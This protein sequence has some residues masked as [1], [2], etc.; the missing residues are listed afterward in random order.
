[1]PSE[2]AEFA[3]LSRWASLLN[4]PDPVAVLEAELALTDTDGIREYAHRTWGDGNGRS[5]VG[6]DAQVSVEVLQRRFDI[7]AADGW[8][9]RSREGFA[10]WLSRMRA[11]VESTAGRFATIGGIAVA[12]AD[13][14]DEAYAECL[15]RFADAARQV[16]AL[17]LGRDED[18]P[19]TRQR[20]AREIE[21]AIKA[22]AVCC[23]RVDERVDELQPAVE[24]LI[25][26]TSA[27]GTHDPAGTADWEPL[28]DPNTRNVGN[29]G[30]RAHV[31]VPGD[32]LS[33]L[34]ARYLGDADRWPEI[35]AANRGLIA[36]AD[37]IYPGQELT[38]PT[39]GGGEDTAGVPE[40]GEP[41]LPEPG[42]PPEHNGEPGH[43][44][45]GAPAPD[46]VPY[47]PAP[48]PSNEH[49]AP[50]PSGGGE[51][52]PGGNPDAE[53]SAGPAVPDLVSEVARVPP[54]V[55]VAA[56]LAAA[57]L[58]AWA[59]GVLLRRRSHSPTDPNSPPEPP[60]SLVE[61]LLRHASEHPGTTAA[62][63]HEGAPV[64][65]LGVDARGAP[66][67]AR[68]AAGGLGLHGPGADHAARAVIAGTLCAGGPLNP[69]EK[70]IVV[71]THDVLSMLTADPD[72]GHG[73]SR[74]V[75][76]ADIG[77]VL[78]WLSIEMV[79]RRRILQEHGAST[80]E[81]LPRVDP[82]AAPLPLIVAVLTAPGREHARALQAVLD[83]A[84]D[85]GVVAVLL[86]EWPHASVF[87]DGDCQVSAP[88]G[89]IASSAAGGSLHGGQLAGLSASGFVDA[90]HVAR[91]AAAGEPGDVVLSTVP[92]P[93]P[94]TTSDRIAEASAR[95]GT[96]TDLDPQPASPRITPQDP[97]DGGGP[98]APVAGVEQPIDGLTEAVPD[99]LPVDIAAQLQ[100]DDNGKEAAAEPV[101]DSTATPGTRA[102]V[103]DAG[104]TMALLTV[105]DTP[106]VIAGDH[107]LLRGLR[108]VAREI[109][110]WLALH[111]GGGTAADIV[112]DLWPGRSADDK[113]TRSSFRGAVHN[114]RSALAA[115]CRRPESGF[116][117]H[118]R[119]TGRYT[120]SDPDVR[121]EW[122]V[123]ES[124][125]RE[126]DT[127]CALDD[128]D[129]EVRALHAA[130]AL[131]R[132]PLAE[133]WQSAWLVTF[134]QD[135]L[136]QA[137]RALERLSD[138]ACPDHLDEA[139]SY[140]QQAIELDPYAEPCY[141]ALMQ[142]QAARG[143]L[144]DVRH[145]LQR[146]HTQLADLDAEP[147]Q[148]TIVLAGKLLAGHT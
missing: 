2:L 100:G 21:R 12:A 26:P 135:A 72:P 121:S 22:V 31:V 105:F 140:L 131:C 93:R 63:P 44:E 132:A 36:D 144:D 147:D 98:G 80:V 142:V 46:P 138:L 141:R 129:G 83:Q 116:V 57:V 8:Q 40:T 137:T 136:N 123:F 97:V 11:E 47:R 133:G 66:I 124:L 103:P 13:T 81:E 111:P 113:N 143:D 20:V 49:E 87:V 37:L 96:S 85:L 10:A 6:D 1:M 59:L 84:A 112:K 130:T 128:R 88:S 78:Q 122:T 23:G 91:L 101:P 90:L 7:D 145:T 25:E 48:P 68:H 9:G 102:P 27:G 33:A 28:S 117:P 125:L 106:K 139:E 65:A 92:R 30:E 14:V 77:E 70:S 53:T 79:R 71:T 148:E 61:S 35:Y 104:P 74:L 134:Q 16:H 58:A 54:Q 17:S 89:Q 64:P 18:H 109:L 60:P 69:D 146:L 56:G 76:L 15:V 94:P 99:E 50:P 120:L 3:V 4:L 62:D 52:Q 126:A 75:R 73:M 110:L 29:V 67:Q 127:A 55:L 24:A 41:Q 107:E 39:A 34:A 108:S 38:I 119:D 45:P 51:N 86:G 95:Q 114:A 118:D 32:T 19:E 5:A 43:R 115:A 82:Y 42:T